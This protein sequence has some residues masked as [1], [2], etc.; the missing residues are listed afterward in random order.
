VGLASSEVPKGDEGD[1]LRGKVPRAVRYGNDRGEAWISGEQGIVGIATV[2]MVGGVDACDGQ[3]LLSTEVDVD[4][5]TFSESGVHRVL[6]SD[7]GAL[8]VDDGGC[9]TK[10]GTRRRVSSGT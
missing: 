2:A 5:S 4:P 3:L 10:N 6:D 1:R 9:T 8:V 7:P